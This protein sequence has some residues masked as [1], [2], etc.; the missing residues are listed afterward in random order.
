MI[1]K[2]ALTQ[3]KAIASTQV[4]PHVNNNGQQLQY[5][6]TSSKSVGVASPA[7]KAKKQKENIFKR[8]ELKATKSVA[9]VYFTFLICWLPGAIVAII[10]NFDT[11]KKIFT[12]L[13]IKNK[14]AFLFIY[15]GLTKTLVMLNTMLNPIIYSFSNEQFRHAFRMVYSKM[16]GNE[17]RGSASYYATN[18]STF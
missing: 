17:N 10:A 9:I 3:I 7:T 8:R 13:Y 14:G 6:M 16:F 4:Q 12:Q 18:T 15:L 2:I 1:L 5:E 11:E